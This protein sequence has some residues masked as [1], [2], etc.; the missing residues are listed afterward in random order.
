MWL[1]TTAGLLGLSTI[2]FWGF[3]KT[4]RRRNRQSITDEIPKFGKLTIALQFYAPTKIE[5]GDLGLDFYD[6]AD[7]YRPYRIQR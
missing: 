2:E 7:M 4:D 1:L 5:S 6:I 3:R